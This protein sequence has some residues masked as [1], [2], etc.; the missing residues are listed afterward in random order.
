MARMFASCATILCLTLCVTNKDIY[1]GVEAFTI[2]RTAYLGS[3]VNNNGVISR[4]QN[5]I[6]RSSPRTSV[7]VNVGK[8]E[9]DFSVEDPE[10]AKKSKKKKVDKPPANDEP[11]VNPLEGVDI[12]SLILPVGALGAVGVAGAGALALRSALVGSKDE[13][14]AQQQQQQSRRGSA[15]KQ[16]R[17]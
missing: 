11:F 16:G 13:R 10:E 2:P 6:S 17:T 12:S 8:F 14:E 15:G 9:Y 7:V 3:S 4:T 5:T 1:N